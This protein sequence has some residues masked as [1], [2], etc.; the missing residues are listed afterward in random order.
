MGASKFITFLLIV[1]TLLLLGISYFVLEIFYYPALRASFQ[2]QTVSSPLPPQAPSQV[3]TSKGET[4]FDAFYL[5]LSPL[6]QRCIT[7]ALGQERTEELR[8]NRSLS[9]SGEEGARIQNC[10]K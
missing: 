10:L 5:S 9:A 3:S 8:R 6:R 1:N 2:G 4:S 7:D